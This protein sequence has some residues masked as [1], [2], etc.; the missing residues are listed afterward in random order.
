MAKK[1]RN[2]SPELKS[3]RFPFTVRALRGPRPLA[4]RV[5]AHESPGVDHT[6][7]HGVDPNA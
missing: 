6:I 7:P 3:S 1:S 2:I 4:R 5:E